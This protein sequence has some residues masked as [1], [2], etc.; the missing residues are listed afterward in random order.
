[1]ACKITVKKQGSSVGTLRLF[2]A[3]VAVLPRRQWPFFLT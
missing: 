2:Y 3:M 1:M